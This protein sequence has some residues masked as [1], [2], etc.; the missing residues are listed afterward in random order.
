VDVFGLEISEQRAFPWKDYALD[1]VDPRTCLVLRRMDGTAFKGEPDLTV[2]AFGRGKAYYKAS[3]SND[4][5][6]DDLLDVVM[7]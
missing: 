4:E 7:K 1:R 5:K 6:M 2:N 3:V